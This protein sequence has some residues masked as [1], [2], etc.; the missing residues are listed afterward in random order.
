MNNKNKKKIFPMKN[1]ISKKII[2]L[3]MMIK[4]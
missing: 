2:I 1:K 4:F 3:I